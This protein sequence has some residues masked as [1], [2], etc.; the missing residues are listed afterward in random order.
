[1]RS[2]A[3][4]QQVETSEQRVVEAGPRDLSL[5]DKMAADEGDR[6]EGPR[7]VLQEKRASV[8]DSSHT[9]CKFDDLQTDDIIL[10]F[11][12]SP[13]TPS[14]SWARELIIAKQ[15]RTPFASVIDTREGL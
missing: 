9:K 12:E 1:M 4:K 2:Q 3:T 11:R 10:C 7:E 8:H 15:R 5:T 14:I 6:R 13:T